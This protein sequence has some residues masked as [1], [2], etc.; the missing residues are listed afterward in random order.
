MP[1]TL[2]GTEAGEDRSAERFLPLLESP[3]F[4]LERIVSYGHATPPGQWYD[5]DRPEWVLL[6]RGRAVL[7][8][9]GGCEGR[10]ELAAGDHLLI[11][12][13]ARHRVEAVSEDAVWLALHFEPA[14]G[15][16]VSMP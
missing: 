12:A 15:A 1:G 2:F 9:D 10:L 7:L 16:N 5:Q 3:A 8:F 13:R 6:A 14:A 11:P 4:R